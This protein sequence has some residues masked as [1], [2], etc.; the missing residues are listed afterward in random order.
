M[1]NTF[2]T[3]YDGDTFEH[4]GRKFRVRL[5]R[6]EFCSE[7]WKECDGHGVV[8]D[9]TTREKAPGERILHSDRQ[10]KLYYD[11]RESMKRAR[12]E[13]WDTEPYGQGTAGERAARAVEA[14]FQFLR[15]WCNDEWEYCFVDVVMLDSDG[16]ETGFR[17]SLGGVESWKDYHV[18]AAHDLAAELIEEQRAELRAAAKERRE[19][20]YLASR[21]VATTN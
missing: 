7:P 18:E 17:Q 3:L 11:V 4:E 8:S 15:A 14:D 9:W 21:D 12:A 5:E 19:A 16:N 1:K 2:R 6:D 20:R 13:G 10:H